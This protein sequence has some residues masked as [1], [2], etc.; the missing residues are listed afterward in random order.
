LIAHETEA[1]VDGRASPLFRFLLRKVN[2]LDLDRDD[3]AAFTLDAA[4]ARR[5]I[6]VHRRT[7]KREKPG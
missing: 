6:R 2:V 7:R 4:G 5:I 3:L 1:C